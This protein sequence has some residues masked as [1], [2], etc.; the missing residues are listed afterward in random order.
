MCSIM[1]PI[2][3]LLAPLMVS[4]VTLEYYRSALCDKQQQMFY[5]DR[6]NTLSLYADIACHQ[7]PARTFA[8]RSRGGIDDGCFG[9]HCPST[10]LAAIG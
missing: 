7:T 2:T 5:L 6:Y 3:L 9:E 4:A 10:F 1:F 8:I